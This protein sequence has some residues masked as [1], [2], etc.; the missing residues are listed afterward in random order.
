MHSSLHDL[1]ATGANTVSARVTVEHD[2]PWFTG[3]FPGD[4]IL[5]GIAQLQMVVEAVGRMRQEAL[6]LRQ[7]NRIKFKKIVRPGACLDIHA[8]ATGTTDVYSF[9]IVSETQEVCTGTMLLTPET[10]EKTVP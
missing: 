2:S 1:K 6:R 4:A 3:H 10:A 8:T 7:L 9:T 5:P